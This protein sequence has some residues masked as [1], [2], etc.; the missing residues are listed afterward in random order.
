MAITKK[1]L[2]TNEAIAGLIVEDEDI[3][4]YLYYILPR[5]DYGTNRATKGETLNTDSV[6]DLEIPY[7]IKTIKKIV[8]ELDKLEEERQEKVKSKEQ[9]EAEQE[10]IIKAEIFG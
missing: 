6:G 7:D 10:K 2:Y 3:K 5:L 8:K 9:L 4:K 1:P